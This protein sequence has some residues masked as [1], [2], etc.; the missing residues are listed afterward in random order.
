MVYILTNPHRAALVDSIEEYPNISSWGAVIKGEEKIRAKRIPRDSITAL[1]KASI[2]LRKQEVI[3]RGLLE[4]S[5]EEHTLVIKPFAWMKCFAETEGAASED[6]R[7]QLIREVRDEERRL[8]AQ[9]VLENKTVIGAHA[10]RLQRMD[11]EYTPT[12]RAP[13]VVCISSFKKLRIRF[14]EWHKDLAKAAR[15]V[16]SQWKCGER[17]VPMPP[18][19]LAP[20]GLLHANIIPGYFPM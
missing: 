3:A 9:R 18:G 17:H 15:L 8:R 2:G 1:P 4:A 6:L 19:M 20:G 5:T 10:L 14:I 11:Q 12:K 13:R 7:E 16:F